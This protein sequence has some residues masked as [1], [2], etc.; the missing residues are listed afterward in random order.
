MT[1]AFL[2]FLERL[3]DS[4]DA[5]QLETTMSAAAAALDLSD[6]AYLALPGRPNEGAR[7]ISTYRTAWTSHYLQSRYERIDPVI[8]Q[9]QAG[10]QPFE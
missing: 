6:F 4:V 5:V 3:W 1:E 8:V 10:T 9:A 7:L 2:Q